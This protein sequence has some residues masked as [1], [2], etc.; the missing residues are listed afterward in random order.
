[1]EPIGKKTRKRVNPD[2]VEMKSDDESKK[3]KSDEPQET[4]D[5]AE[6]EVKVEASEVTSP[7]S[8]E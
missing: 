8:N 7:P 3:S 5:T 1:M 6:M 2:D 4:Q